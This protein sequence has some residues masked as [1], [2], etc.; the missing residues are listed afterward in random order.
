MCEVILAAFFGAHLC[1]VGLCLISSEYSWVA[2]KQEVQT[3]KE[4]GADAAAGS[5]HAATAATT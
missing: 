2:T 1:L 4:E 3:N 5:N